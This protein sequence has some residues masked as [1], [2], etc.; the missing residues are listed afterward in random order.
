MRK[1]RRLRHRLAA[2]N[3][4]TFGNILSHKK[5]ILDELE[6]L[7]RLEESNSLPSALWERLASLKSYLTL[8][9][10]Q[11]EVMWGQRSRVRWLKEG[12][13]NIS[14]FHKVANSRRLGNHISSV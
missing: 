4:S 2:W 12:D 6:S 5:V 9:A 7:E 11:E 10:G 3:L 1:L 13:T 8:I 14:F